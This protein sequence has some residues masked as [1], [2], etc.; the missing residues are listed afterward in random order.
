MKNK[1]FRPVWWLRSPHMQTI[2]PF[3]FRRNIHLD[4]REE[5]LELDDG[6]FLDLN[7]SR[8]FDNGCVDGK[9]IL[10]I[11]GLEGSLDSHY[12]AGLMQTLEECGYYPVFMHFR[13][14]SGRIN[15]LPRAYH[16]GDT[17][18]IATVVEHITRQTGKKV[19]AAVGFSLGANAL[20]KWLGESGEENPLEAAIA[21][22][23]PF[24][25]A[26]A[27]KRLN[28]GFS[29]FYRQY[30]LTS[31]CN[32]YRQKFS[33]IPSPLDIE[34]EQIKSLW[35]YDDSITAPL[36]GFDGADHYYKVSSCRQY[37]KDIKIKTRIIHSRDDPFMYSETAPCS[38]E[39]SD[40]TEL[41]LAEYGGH[42][43]FVRWQFPFKV[44]YWHEEKI[45]EFLDNS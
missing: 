29:K 10:V 41:L 13:G 18:D 44:D 19:F 32:S 27:V 38:D 30:L 45:C 33:V 24:Q 11:H 36:H 37:L 8:R 40:S 26:D 34:I 6:D 23:V 3:L 31:L 5:Q 28:Q 12:S 2:W 7:W 4:L 35:Q 43:G 14:C 39:L 25:L 15:R 20:L 22:S 16:S 42:V 9:I 17:A 21:V 1:P